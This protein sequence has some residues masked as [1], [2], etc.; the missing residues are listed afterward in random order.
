MLFQTHHELFPTQTGVTRC[1]EQP[2]GG[3]PLQGKRPYNHNHA[4]IGFTTHTDSPKRPTPPLSSNTIRATHAQMHHPALASLSSG[5]AFFG[6]TSSRV[7]VETFMDFGHYGMSNDC[8]LHP[9]LSGLA[10]LTTRVRALRCQQDRAKNAY[11][12]NY[13][14]SFMK[15]RLSMG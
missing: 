1:R 12:S 13:F 3:A 8:T 5:I 6:E 4:L 10:P 9:G 15:S 11:F 7:V 14:F 2:H